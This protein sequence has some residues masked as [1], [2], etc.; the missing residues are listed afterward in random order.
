[1]GIKWEE[2]GCLSFFWGEM[3]VKAVNSDWKH[4]M[5]GKWEEKNH[6]SE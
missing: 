1:L 4:K 2:M 5:N 3:G 6:V